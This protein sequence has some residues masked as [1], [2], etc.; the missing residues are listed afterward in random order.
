MGFV[1]LDTDVAALSLRGRVPDGLRPHLVGRTWCVSP[2]T[3]AEMFQWAQLR[4]WTD[5]CRAALD[6]WLDGV[7][8]VSQDVETARW[9]GTLSGFGKLEARARPTNAIWVAACCLTE[10][11]PLVTTDRRDYVDLV[12]EYGLRLLGGSAS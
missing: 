2:V 6:A 11:L 8:V 10:D 5:T 4:S 9:W 7:V 12:E 3:V 1:V